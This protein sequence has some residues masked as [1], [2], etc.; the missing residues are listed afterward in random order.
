MFLHDM[1]D[2][3]M[4]MAKLFLYAGNEFLANVFFVLFSVTFIISRDFIF[5]ICLIAPLTYNE[6][7]R[8]VPYIDVYIVA[9]S[10]IG[11]LNIFWSY[12]ILSMIK[13]HIISGDVKGD[14]REE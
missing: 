11:V 6:I 13:R 10:T 1:S 9:L 5:P 4:E 3:L 8:Q 12:L 2:P 7:G 14:I